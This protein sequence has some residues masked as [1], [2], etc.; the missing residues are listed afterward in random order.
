MQTSNSPTRQRLGQNNGT[1]GRPAGMALLQ[2][3]AAAR[4]ALQEIMADPDHG[5]AALCSETRM[6]H[7]L[8]DFLPD[9]PREAAILVS[10]ARNRVASALCDNVAQG[11]DTATAVRIAAAAFAEAS[12]IRPEAC[13][14]AVTEL[15][16]ALGLP[17]PAPAAANEGQNTPPRGPDAAAQGAAPTVVPAVRPEPVSPAHWPGRAPSADVRPAGG[18]KRSRPKIIAFAAGAAAAL[19]LIAG[20]VS[21]A[22][23]ATPPVLRPTGLAT[24]TSSASSVSI[25]WAAPPTGPAPDR[26]VVSRDGKVIDSVP[27][28]ITRYR[29]RGL[30]PATEYRYQVTAVRG[31]T[32]SPRS[33]ILADST[34]TPTVSAA[35][36]RGP[37][38]VRYHVLKSGGGTFATG[39][40]WTDSWQ[41]TPHCPSGPCSV[42]LSGVITGPGNFTPMPF[43]ATL[44]RHGAVYTGTTS[45][46]I[47][48]CNGPTHPVR[49][50]LSFRITL[51]GAGVEHRAWTATSWTGT[52]VLSS[53]YTSGGALYCAAQTVTTSIASNH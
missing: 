2:H 16:L 17:G 9:A 32:R 52:L 33:A 5:A 1:P 13:D 14:W 26:Y 50:T 22:P 21:W 31:S 41:F 34:I 19:A 20:L 10:A 15:A 53:P 49:S 28:T 8:Q 44:T 43:T 7:L 36:L 29:D 38:A 39:T 27:G 3:A 11:M 4:A 25:S 18:T 12:M 46:H 30:A 37:W 42:Q 51:S 23:W 24:G 35:T 48:N 6:A 45:A 47:V 40:R